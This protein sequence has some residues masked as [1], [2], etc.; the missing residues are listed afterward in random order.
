MK[1]D[2]WIDG[3]PVTYFSGEVSAKVI[4]DD[5]KLAI[6]ALGRDRLHEH[7]KLF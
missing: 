6:G 5:V 3:Q 7:E 2:V 1:R 4:H